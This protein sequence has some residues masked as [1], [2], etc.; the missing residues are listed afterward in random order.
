MPKSNIIAGSKN[1]TRTICYASRTLSEV[2]GKYSYTK[3]EL[4]AVV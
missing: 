3:R 4:L 1:A 2:E